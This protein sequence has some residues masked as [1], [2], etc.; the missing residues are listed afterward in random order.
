[1][2]ERVVEDH[3]GALKHAGRAQRQ[4][5]GCAGAGADEVDLAHQS[6]NPA[7]TVWLVTVQSCLFRQGLITVGR[8]PKPNPKVSTIFPKRWSHN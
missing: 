2:D 5:I 6:I 4:E 8:Q 7:A 1:M 3:I